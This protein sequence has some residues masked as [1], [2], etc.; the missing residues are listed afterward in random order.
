MR[1]PR[2]IWNRGLGSPNFASKVKS[3]FTFVFS[4]VVRQNLS[5]YRYTQTFPLLPLTEESPQSAIRQDDG[6]QLEQEA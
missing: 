2:L 3:L 6:D 1:V 5:L 4:E